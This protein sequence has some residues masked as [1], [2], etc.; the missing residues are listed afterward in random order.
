SSKG[1]PFAF[2]KSSLMSRSPPLT[3]SPA[4]KRSTTD[5]PK[6]SSK[7]GRDPAS[8]P[9]GQKGTVPKKSKAAEDEPTSDAEDKAEWNLTRVESIAR[10]GKL[11]DNLHSLVFEKQMRHIPMK[12]MI[13]EMRKLKSGIEQPAEAAGPV[14]SVSLCSIC[15]QSTTGRK[16]GVSTG[17]QTRAV[18]R[19][20]RAVQTEPRRRLS[21]SEGAVESVKAR[22]QA[23]GTPA[24]LVAPPPRSSGKK[25]SPAPT[26]RPRA[27]ENRQGKANPA[28]P[29][30]GCPWSTVAR[31]K[32]QKTRSRPDAVVV[33]AAGKTYSEILAMVTRRDD[34]Q[35][36]DLGGAVKTVRRTARGN[37]LLEVARGGTESAESMRASISRVLGDEAEV[38]ALTEESKVSVFVIRNL[39]AITTES[40]IRN[41]FSKQFDLC[42]GAVKIR[43]LRSGYAES[44]TAV[45]SLPS[46]MAKEVRLRG[47]VRIGWTRC[48]VRE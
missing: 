32:R 48:R 9:S 36:S 26:S 13:A 47:E 39:D 45:I 6:D 44:K 31:K 40:E 29:E 41:A 43:S 24:R 12:S 22:R 25:A 10:L 15:A 30:P 20:D 37:L 38:R 21:T 33:E 46:S 5:D 28:E 14:A 42:E 8:P 11:I 34:S 23:R 2:R 1:E 18:P 7:R 17:Q 35:L 4:P 3:P 19:R 27:P 16:P